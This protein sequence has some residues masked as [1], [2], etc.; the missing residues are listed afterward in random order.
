MTTTFKSTY[1]KIYELTDVK[2]VKQELSFG[3]GDGIGNSAHNYKEW[4]EYAETILQ[5]VAFV[6]CGFQSDI[7]KR[8]LEKPFRLSEKQEWA[9]AF[10]FINNKSQQRFAS[11]LEKT[12]EELAKGIEKAKEEGDFEF[13]E[14]VGPLATVEELDWLV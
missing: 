12:N 13:I 7:A 14:L 11:F 10:A 9:V 3:I 2:K 8:A 4:D 6:E 1:Q 5:F